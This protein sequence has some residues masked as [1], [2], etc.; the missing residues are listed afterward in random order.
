MSAAPLTAWNNYANSLLE[1]TLD[2]SANRRTLFPETF[3]ALDEIVMTLA[4][5]MEGLKV[6]PVRMKSNLEKFGPFA[7]VER[8]MLAAVKNG[9]DRQEMHEV[10]RQLSMAAWQAVEK[11]EA[12]PLADL[13]AQDERVTKW[14]APADLG[15]L[16]AVE[17][18]TGMA[19]PR[20]REMAQKIRTEL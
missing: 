13:V 5:I 16:F 9:A 1:R 11:G 15:Q 7:A 8:V 10:L 4:K 12:N 6:N 2:D 3:L 20:A 17:D 19:E 14:V 18:Y